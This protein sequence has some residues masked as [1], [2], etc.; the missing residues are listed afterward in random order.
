M[1]LLL[2]PDFNHVPK[3]NLQMT[4]KSS[5]SITKKRTYCLII[6]TFIITSSFLLSFICNM[7]NWMLMTFNWMSLFTR[8]F[9]KSVS[10]FLTY[11]GS[12]DSKREPCRG[13]VAEFQMQENKRQVTCEGSENILKCFAHW[14][15]W[16]CLLRIPAKIQ[17]SV[18]FF[19][20][21]L[22]FRCELR[23]RIIKIFS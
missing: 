20:F 9:S 5:S 11:V 16:L 3:L 17:T 7:F 19:F 1:E 18:F 2:S 10:P 15:K 8:D 22:R 23:H 4:P 12:L 14:K 21:P 6:L 13:R